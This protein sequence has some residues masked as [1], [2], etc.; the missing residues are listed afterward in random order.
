MLLRGWSIINVDVNYMHSEGH[1]EGWTIKISTYLLGLF[2][3]IGVAY[4]DC[5]LICALQ[6]LLLI[7]LLTYLKG[8]ENLENCTA[9]RRVTTA[10]WCYFISQASISIAR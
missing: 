5:L 3:G 1:G 8:W 6:I 10:T 4:R 2:V 7:Y 9:V